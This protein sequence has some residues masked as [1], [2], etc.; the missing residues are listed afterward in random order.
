M[1]SINSFIPKHLDAEWLYKQYVEYERSLQDIAEECGVSAVAVSK[2]LKRNNIKARPFQGRKQP[3]AVTPEQKRIRDKVE[4]NFPQPSLKKSTTEQVDRSPHLTPEPPE[5]NQHLVLRIDLGWTHP[6]TRWILMA[7]PTATFMDLAILI[8]AVLKKDIDEDLCHFVVPANGKPPRRNQAPFWRPTMEDVV[9]PVV[10]NGNERYGDQLV[11]SDE[12]PLSV[13]LGKGWTCWF[14]WSYQQHVTFCIRVIEATM[15][16]E[17]PPDSN[18]PFRFLATP[19]K[20]P[21]LGRKDTPS[22]DPVDIA[23]RA[24]R[25][26]YRERQGVGGTRRQK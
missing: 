19:T 6:H 2:S 13:A 16:P 21:S 14:H 15:Q 1:P 22:I 3:G 8:L 12:T 9:V 7:T 24:T 4:K 25:A 26:I 5:K 11:G 23:S 20:L 18:D 17:F 10:V